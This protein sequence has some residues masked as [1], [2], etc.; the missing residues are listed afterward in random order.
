MCKSQIVTARCTRNTLKIH[1]L[2]RY[3]GALADPYRTYLQTRGREVGHPGAVQGPITAIERHVVGNQAQVPRVDRDAV[4]PED[5]DD[6]GNDRGSGGL[7]AVGLA[8]SP[9]V[10]RSQLLC[11]KN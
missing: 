7:H 6:L 3:L 1:Q 11:G 9:N 2:A 8:H 10:V 4:R 5:V